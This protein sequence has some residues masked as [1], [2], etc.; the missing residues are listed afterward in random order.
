MLGFSTMTVLQLTSAVKQFMAQKPIT[1]IEH[2]PYS[3]DFTSNDFL[4]FL[5]MKCA[6]EGRIFKDSEDQK[7]M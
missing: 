2:P 5:N 3:H 7:K 1:E 4:L 6:L